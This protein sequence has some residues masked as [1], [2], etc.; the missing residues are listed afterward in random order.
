MDQSRSRPREEGGVWPSRYFAHIYK[1]SFVARQDLCRGGYLGQVETG[2]FAVHDAL[3]YIVR[4][5][6]EEGEEVYP[7]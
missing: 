5:T 1:I 6:V 2:T 3:A 7:P 4:K